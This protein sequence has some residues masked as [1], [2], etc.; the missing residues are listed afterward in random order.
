MKVIAFLNEKGG[1]GKSTVAIN[2]ATA[3]HRQ[4]KKTVLLDA[5]PQATAR[6][7]RESAA[8][9]ANV[10]PVLAAD[11]P[12]TLTSALAGLSADFVVID[13]PAKAESI[14]ASII[15]K[16]DI[17]LI[18]MQPSAAD[19]WASAAMVKMIESKRNLGGKIDAAF[20]VNRATTGR[21]LTAEILGGEWNEYG[22]DQ[23]DSFVSDRESFKRALA[24]GTTVFDTNDSNAK[25]EIEFVIDELEKAEWL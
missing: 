11:R 12:N 22:I 14:S 9:D 17:A 16:A 3:L 25:A 19:V 24:N 2:F 7:W 10:P 8:V 5:D 4:G 23:L 13:G 6:D 21:A 18:V 1:T 15:G 20:L